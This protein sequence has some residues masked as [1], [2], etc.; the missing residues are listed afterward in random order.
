MTS[1]DQMESNESSAGSRGEPVRGCRQQ[2]HIVRLCEAD[3]EK[4]AAA[5]VAWLAAG[6]APAYAGVTLDAA[7]VAAQLK[8]LLQLDGFV[9]L[10]LMDG[11]EIVGT[12]VGSCAPEWFTPDIVAYELFFGLREDYRS[13]RNAR[14]LITAFEVIAKRLGASRVLLNCTSGY[15]YERVSVLYSRFGYTQIGAQ[16]MK[17]V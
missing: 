6:I 2:L 13:M 9:A 8:N 12:Y 1:Q 14:M 16:F 11:D 4:G 15:Q 5:T 3:A 17:E 10:A 7:H